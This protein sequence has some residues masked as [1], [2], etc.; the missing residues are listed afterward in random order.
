MSVEVT[1]VPDIP[2]ATAYLSFGYDRSAIA[3]SPSVDHDSLMS[4]CR[5]IYSDSSLYPFSANASRGT[6]DQTEVGHLLEL[7]R[8]IAVAK[9]GA[10]TSTG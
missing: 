2:D 7:S 8:L 6:V 5:M 4:T 9:R 1:I 10:R 3:L